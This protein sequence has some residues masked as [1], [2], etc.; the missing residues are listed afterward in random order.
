M[1]ATAELT[2][3]RDKRAGISG[4]AWLPGGS[5]M[6]AIHECGAS[7]LQIHPSLPCTVILELDCVSF[8]L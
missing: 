1:V 4:E 5:R 7:Q 3:V 8:L 2:D 6:C